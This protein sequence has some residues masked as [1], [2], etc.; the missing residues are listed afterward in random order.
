MC[1][2]TAHSFAAGY[3]WRDQKAAARAMK[4]LDKNVGFANVKAVHF[5]D[6]KAPF[7]S[8]VDRHWHIGKGEIGSEGLSRVINHPKLKKLPFILETPQDEKDDDIKN[9]KAAGALAG[10]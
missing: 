7:D 6:S 8:K 10:L 3:D 4:S 5:N 2:D 1:L 9:L